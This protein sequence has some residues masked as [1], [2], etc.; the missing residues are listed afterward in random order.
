MRIVIIRHGQT[1]ANVINDEGTALYT[2]TLNNELTSLT[3]Q[4]KN[5]ASVLSEND[6]IKSI[7]KVY[8]SD[9]IRAI[10]TAKLA[11]YALCY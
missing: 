10:Q 3:E 1:V 4:G 2:G 9:L 7:E 5:Q 6:I 11:L 8:S